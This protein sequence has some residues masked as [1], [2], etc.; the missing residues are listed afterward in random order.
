HRR[1]PRRD[2]VARRGPYLLPGLDVERRDERVPA[3]VALEDR[4]PLVDQRGVP[5]A[6]LV[7]PV[8][9]EARVERAEVAFPQEPAREV[10]TVQPFRAEAG[11]DVLAVGRRG[12]VG[13]AALPVPLDLRHAL[14]GRPRPEDRARVAVQAKHLPGVLR[15]VVDGSNVAV[16]ADADLR[17]LVAADGRGEE[18]AVAPDDGAGV[19]QPGDR[20]LPADVLPLLEVPADGRLLAVGHARAARA[21]ERRPVERRAPWPIPRF[22]RGGRVPPRLSHATTTPP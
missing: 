17:V 11:D 19:A 9:R 12:A 3:Q 2:L 15:R 22:P 18:D 8:D 14:V 16:V 4:Q 20:R 6:P 1:A 7:L 13:L 21:A 10:V 5:E